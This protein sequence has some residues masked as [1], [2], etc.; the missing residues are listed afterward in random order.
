VGGR[1]VPDSTVSAC[2]NE[3]RNAIDDTDRDHVADGLRKAG[4]S[5]T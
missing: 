2:I 4:L 1:I 5:E 3:A